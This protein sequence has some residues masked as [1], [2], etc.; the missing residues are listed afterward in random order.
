MLRIDVRRMR[1]I[2]LSRQQQ[3][4]FYLL[5]R[6]TDWVSTKSSAPTLQRVTCSVSKSHSH[7]TVNSIVFLSRV[8]KSIENQQGCFVSYLHHYNH[9]RNFPWT[10]GK[11]RNRYWTRSEKFA[12]ISVVEQSVVLQ[13]YP[14]AAQLQK[15][16]YIY[17]YICTLCQVNKKCDCGRNMTYTRK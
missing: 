9:D 4:T 1:I 13:L 5:W 16:K 6:P 10:E 12:F 7:D 17:I 8:E 11:S 2:Q 14:S 15:K 3:V